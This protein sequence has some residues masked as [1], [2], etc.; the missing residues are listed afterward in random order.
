MDVTLPAGH[1]ASERKRRVSQPANEMLHF[2][3]AQ[4]APPEGCSVCGQQDVTLSVSE[5]S[6]GPPRDASLRS[7]AA[8]PTRRVLCEC[9]QHDIQGIIYGIPATVQITGFNSFNMTNFTYIIAILRKYVFALC[10]G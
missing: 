7:C 4:R 1:S 6:P 10:D 3:Y 5:G 2:I 9:G 8:C